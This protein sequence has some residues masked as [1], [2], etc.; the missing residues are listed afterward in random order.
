MEQ[1]LIPKAHARLLSEWE[2]RVTHNLGEIGVHP[3][4]MKELIDDA[5]F[6]E[7]VLTTPLRYPQTNGIQELRERIANLYPGASA[8][9]VVVTI[10]AAQANYTTT[11]TLL[12]PGDAIV[13]MPPTYRQLAGLARKFKFD[14][15][16]VPRNKEAGWSVNI[17]AL[18][19]AVTPQT[20]L[21]YVCNPNNPTGNI[22]TPNEM[23]ALARIAEQAGAW[24]LADEVC[25]GG[26][27]E[28]DEETPTF[29]GYSE[30]VL[31]TNSMSKTYGLPGTRIGWV[32]APNELAYKLWSEQDGVTI[33]A[34][35][36]GNLLSAFALS[37]E[38]RKRILA[39]TRQRVREGWNN[40]EQ[41]LRGHEDAFS[42]TPPQSAALAFLEYRPK[43]NSTDLAWRLIQEK[44]VLVVPGDAFGIDH[45]LRIGTDVPRAQL[46]EALDRIYELFTEAD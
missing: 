23:E 6:L 28:S 44:D 12:A 36:V 1:N 43:I 38:V 46:Y 34:P 35:M 26:E 33:T 22:M 32:I 37:P 3:L 41:W 16:V 25:A 11:L 5:Q 42:I 45:H 17:E 10:G 8:D 27:L 39:R 21:I 40:L 30:H 24:V 14:I 15:K 13:L 20:R 2:N 9:N 19:K 29:W 7:Q 4:S 18:E 31:V